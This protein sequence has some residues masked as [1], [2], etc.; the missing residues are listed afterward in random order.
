MKRLLAISMTALLQAAVA[1]G[2]AAR[3]PAPPAREYSVGVRVGALG[4][5]V[6]ADVGFVKGNGRIRPFVRTARSQ[7]ALTLV[8][9]VVRVGSGQ[10]QPGRTTKVGGHYAVETAGDVRMRLAAGVGVENSTNGI[11]GKT[12]GKALLLG[13]SAPLVAPINSEHTRTVYFG[14]PGK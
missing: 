3:Q 9:G 11:G 13:V 10:H 5:V 2:D 14:K 4:R 12:T 7:G 8:E 1:H 6:G